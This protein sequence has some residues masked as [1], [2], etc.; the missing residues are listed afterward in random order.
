MHNYKTE[1][2]SRRPPS[3]FSAAAAAVVVAA[4]AIV[5]AAAPVASAVAAE[6]Q[7]DDNEHPEAAVVIPAEHKTRPFLRAEIFAVSRA[8]CLLTAPYYA[9]SHRAVRPMR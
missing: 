3:R 9:R 1:R 2:A 7:D 4:A 5:A 6:E 8:R